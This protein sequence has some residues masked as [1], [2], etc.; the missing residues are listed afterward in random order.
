M[1]DDNTIITVVRVELVKS[2]VVKLL[3]DQPF[4]QSAPGEELLTFRPSLQEA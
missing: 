1:V 3:L 2:L 4:F